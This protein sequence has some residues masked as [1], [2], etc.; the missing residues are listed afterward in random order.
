MDE[1]KNP[2]KRLLCLASKYIESET[3]EQY[4]ELMLCRA[5]IT[6]IGVELDL[7]ANSLAFHCNGISQASRLVTD[8]PLT[9]DAKSTIEMLSRSM[10]EDLE[11]LMQEYAL[12]AEMLK[13]RGEDVSFYTA[14]SN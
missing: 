9:L 7:Y 5:R 11:K 10:L 13:Q 4:K 6:Q 3:I 2:Q 8:F 1:V 14:I 12:L